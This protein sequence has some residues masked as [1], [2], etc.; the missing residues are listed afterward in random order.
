MTP[1]KIYGSAIMKTVFQIIPHDPQQNLR[2]T[3]IIDEL[4][5]KMAKSTPFSSLIPVDYLKL[6]P[7]R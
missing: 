2:I 4:A 3:P 1:Q 6:F 5:K 7:F